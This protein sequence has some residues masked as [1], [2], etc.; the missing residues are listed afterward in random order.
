MNNMPDIKETDMPAVS[1][2]DILAVDDTPSSLRLLND[3]LSAEGYRV[4]SAING[5]LALRAA[6][7]QPPDLVLLDANM[8]GLDG[9]EVCHRLKNEPGLQDVP[10]IFVSAMSEMQDKLHGFDIGAVDYVTK[11]F[12]REELLARVR[13]HLELHRLR[14]HL[15]EMVEERTLSLSESEKRLKENLLESVSALAAMVDLRDPYTAGHQ[16]RVAHLAEAIAN[17]LGLPEE[18]IEGLV[19]AAVVHDVGKISIPTEILSK[20]G[21]LNEAEFSLI[22]RHPESGYEILKEIDFPWPMA[23]IVRQHHGRIDGSGYPNGLSG[24]EIVYEARIL[25]IAD[26]I[27]AMASHRPY[28]PG[29]G[30]EKA[31]LEIENNSGRLFDKV[32]VDVVMR[33][34]REK[35]YEYE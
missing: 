16:R 28:R 14:H 25:A 29:F 35:G 18:Q 11:P 12:Q 17:E 13:T 6:A 1:L 4:R 33:L 9:F 3:I 19:L 27:E 7:A 34:F 2:G 5:E 23:T 31:L 26:V 30:I 10:V 15:E 24:E 21:T 20:P 32:V 8:P 22:K